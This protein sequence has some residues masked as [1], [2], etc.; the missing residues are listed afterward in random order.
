MS[1][2]N[3]FQLDNPFNS[4]M[5]KIFDIVL[6]NALFLLC[7]IPVITLGAS[8]SAL[9]YMMLKMVR[10]EE[11]GIIKGFFKAFKENVRQ[12]IP[13]TMLLFVCAGLLLTDLHI[14][15]GTESH[16]AMIMYGGCI[17]LILAVGAVF[18][19]IFPLLSR[20]ENTIKGTIVNAAKIAVTYLPQTICIL[21][22]NSIPIIWTMVSPETFA[23]VFVIWLFVGS[24]V[25]AYLNSLLLIRIF[26]K[27][28]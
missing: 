12:S 10:D 18:G 4:I 20:F 16:A 17:A 5:T 23:P 8:V 7:S 13:L 9:Y 19:Y 26:D 15:R 1:K 22:I 21:F 2:L 3:I 11:S 27:I 24:G 14:L 28:S 6:L 25:A